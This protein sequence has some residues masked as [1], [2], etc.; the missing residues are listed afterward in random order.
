MSEIV[1]KIDGE[2]I[3]SMKAQDKDRLGA[4]RMIKDALQKKAK[5]KR[6]DLTDEDAIGVLMT[7]A[8]QRRESIE[9]FRSGGRE[10]LAAK[11]EGELRL[12][13]SYLPAQMSEEEVAAEVKAAIAACG[14]TTQKD[15]GKVMGILMPR[16]KGKA[17]GK[18]INNIVRALLPA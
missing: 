8:K 9:M 14:A 4:V 10:D 17:D 13:E 3:T 6:A 18:V 7:L 12:I 15:M 11:E 5:D 16:L 1:K 2:Y